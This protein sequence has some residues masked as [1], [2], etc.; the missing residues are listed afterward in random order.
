MIHNW[1]KKKQKTQGHCI[2]QSKARNFSLCLQSSAKA[3][4]Q[5]LWHYLPDA[6]SDSVNL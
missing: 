2:K 6:W 5:D 4:T 1:G 3:E